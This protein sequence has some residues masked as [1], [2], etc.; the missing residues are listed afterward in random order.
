MILTTTIYSIIYQ[1]LCWQFSQYIC[2]LGFLFLI[3]I[4]WNLSRKCPRCTFILSVYLSQ[5]LFV[6]PLYYCIH[7]QFF[8]HRVG[9]AVFLLWA[10]V[11][12]SLLFCLILVPFSGG[13]TIHEASYCL[14]SPGY[15]ILPPTSSQERMM[16]KMPFAPIPIRQGPVV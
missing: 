3:S 6:S 14:G 10:S 16:A 15:F 7:V 2:M 5:E 8:H 9:E 12:Q 1:A 4:H 13:M 11:S